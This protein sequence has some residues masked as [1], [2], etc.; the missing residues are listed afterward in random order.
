MI[1]SFR[2][3]PCLTPSFFPPVEGPCS[4]SPTLWWWRKPPSFS[5]TTPVDGQVIQSML[6]PIEGLIS[7]G[8]TKNSNVLFVAAYSCLTSYLWLMMIFF[9]QAEAEA[10]L[11]RSP[12]LY[13]THESSAP[14]VVAFRSTSGRPALTVS[15]QTNRN[16]LQ[17]NQLKSC[18]APNLHVQKEHKWTLGI[19]P[20]YHAKNVSQ[21]VPS[22]PRLLMLLGDSEG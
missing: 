4:A 15:V 5:A 20:I 16:K 11:W 3:I 19:R 17:T 10:M 8:K 18:T 14:S 22:V 7:W 6:T 1:R 9:D 12:R 21:G 13:I 2:G